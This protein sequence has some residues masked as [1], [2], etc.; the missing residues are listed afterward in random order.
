MAQGSGGPG[1]SVQP[2]ATVRIRK[3][4]DGR[5]AHNLHSRR[6][7]LFR[8]PDATSV[9][10]GPAKPRV[11]RPLLGEDVYVRVADIATYCEAL[12]GF[13]GELAEAMSRV[14]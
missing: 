7:D 9:I 1:Q 6:P 2:S 11:D 5:A 13:W 3:H 10:T 12:I 14:S 8:H 4:G